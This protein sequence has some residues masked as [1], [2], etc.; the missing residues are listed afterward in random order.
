MKNRIKD[1]FT[2]RVG[3]FIVRCRD[4]K[5]GADLKYANAVLVEGC[6]DRST[7]WPFAPMPGEH[8]LEAGCGNGAFTIYASARGASIVA[9]DPN[10][11]SAALARRN[12]DSNG[13]A[14]EVHHGLLSTDDTVVSVWFDRT[15][16]TRYSTGDINGGFPRSIKRF[17]VSEETSR[18]KAQDVPMCMKLTQC[19]ETIKLL[20]EAEVF[21]GFEKAVIDYPWW[22]DGSALNFWRRRTLLKKHFKLVAHQWVPEFGEWEGSDTMRVWC[23]NEYKSV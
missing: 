11:E 4:T 23:T 21:A 8:W 1:N 18:W 9:F 14:G 12:L 22:C 20:D 7:P 19:F 10:P 3:D 2:E 15:D 5:Q 16:P 13:L 17:P 6:Y